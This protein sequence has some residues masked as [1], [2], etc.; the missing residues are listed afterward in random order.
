MGSTPITA[1]ITVILNNN[2]GGTITFNMLGF[3]E[4]NLEP[5]GYPPIVVP[6]ITNGEQNTTILQS[7]CQQL[8][9]LG[10]NGPLEEN[11][12]CAG[13]ATFNLPNGQPLTINWNLNAYKGGPMPLISVGPNYSIT[14]NTNPSVNGFNY[15]FNITVSPVS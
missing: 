9:K 3:M 5:G 4:G 11:S 8:I 10:V 2:S 7:Y 12:P 15:T 6:Y 14:G 1:S 13:I